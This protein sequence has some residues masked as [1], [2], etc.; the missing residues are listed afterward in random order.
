MGFRPVYQEEI[1]TLFLLCFTLATIF[2]VKI[3]LFLFSISSSHG[4]P[5]KYKCRTVITKMKLNTRTSN[6]GAEAERSYFF[7]SI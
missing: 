7:F 5:L 1:V 6:L 3:F 4:L 2:Q